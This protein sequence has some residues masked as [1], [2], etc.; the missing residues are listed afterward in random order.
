MPPQGTDASVVMCGLYVCMQVCTFTYINT[1]P[2]VLDDNLPLAV[3]LKGLVEH[4][5]WLAV[6]FEHS[7]YSRPYG[8]LA[9]SFVAILFGFGLA[10]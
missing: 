9:Y 2:R 3:G 8:P 4:S 10:L 1:E 7:W 5:A 6:S